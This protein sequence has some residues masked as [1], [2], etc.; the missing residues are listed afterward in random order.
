MGKKCSR[1]MDEVYPSELTELK[2]TIVAAHDVGFNA[3]VVLILKT[4]IELS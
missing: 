1:Y 4:G 2:F 3:A